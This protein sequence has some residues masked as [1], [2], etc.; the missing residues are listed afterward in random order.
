MSRPFWRRRLKARPD[1]NMA[2]PLLTQEQ[3][4][5]VID[6]LP[7]QG[8]IMLRLLLLQ[9]LDVTQE[10][11]DYIAADR[12]D[13]RF[14]SGFKPTVQAISLETIGSVVDRVAQY[15]A[16]LRQKRERAWLQISCLRK[17]IELSEWLCSV[18][19][20]LLSSRFGLDAEQLQEVKKQAPTA[21]PKPAI[22]E[23]DRQ[24]EKN[25]IDEE[26]YL[27][28]RLIIEHQTQLRRLDREHRRLKSAER[29]YGVAG[30]VALQDHEIAHIWGIPS[31][32]LVARKVKH[33]H[34]Y[35][36]ALLAKVRE[37][38]PTAFSADAPPPDLW[39]ET[40]A[41]LSHRPVERSIAIYDGL[42]RTEAALLDKLKLLASGTMT[43]EIE[44]RFWP[45]VSQSL[46]A[47][48]RLSAIQAETELSPDVVEQELI[49]RLSPKPR[50]ALTA[51]V[52]EEGKEGEQPLSE[53]AQHVLRSLIGEDMGQKGGTKW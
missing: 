14:Q 51:P 50:A 25:E 38:Q 43:E 1:Q 29:E 31:G 36:Q 26:G 5:S 49:A 21:V 16:Q 33:L 34:H 10:D 13:P 7:L 20:E 12:P 30:A 44:G 27:K 23:L 24:W 6:A 11:I 40:F 42:E 39:K 8:R 3:I 53:E 4:V 19:S 32:S 48:Q 37:A 52:A 35:L 15:R 9:Y 45:A 28:E 46:F 22:R 2:S 47:L 17:Q 41:M 18:A